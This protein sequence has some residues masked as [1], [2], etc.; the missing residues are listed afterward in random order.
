MVVKKGDEEGKNE[1][2]I[3]CQKVSHNV[4]PSTV[5]RRG[6]CVYC[7]ISQNVCTVQYNIT[8]FY[9]KYVKKYM[10]KLLL[11]GVYYIEL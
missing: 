8:E 3:R 6:A 9:E 10:K 7:I 4:F 2:V 11:Y 1:S 5:H